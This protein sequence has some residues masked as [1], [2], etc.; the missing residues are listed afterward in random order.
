MAE[1]S[2]VHKSI[3]RE[4]R[5]DNAKYQVNKNGISGKKKKNNCALLVLLHEYFSQLQSV[6]MDILCFFTCLFVVVVV[7]RRRRMGMMTNKEFQKI[8]QTE[9]MSTICG[10]PGSGKIL[11]WIKT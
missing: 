5:K 7:L 11:R 8:F 9:N 10:T 6:N 1:C 4:C 2:G 3:I